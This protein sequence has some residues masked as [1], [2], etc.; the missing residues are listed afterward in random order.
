MIYIYR[1]WKEEEYLPK[2]MTKLL[3]WIKYELWTNSELNKEEIWHVVKKKKR[4]GKHTAGSDEAKTVKTKTKKALPLKSAFVTAKGTSPFAATSEAPADRLKQ[5]KTE[6]QQN[7]HVR[8][9]SEKKARYNLEQLS[10][11]S[12]FQWENYSCAYD[13]LLLI[14]HCLFKSHS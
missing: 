14:L 10:R 11:Y 13:S 5:K 3:K 6:P 8:D 9:H 4:K 7:N 2:Q 12:G 1:K